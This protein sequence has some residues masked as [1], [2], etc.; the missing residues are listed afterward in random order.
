MGG[1]KMSD[2]FRLWEF[3]IKYC[4][5]IDQGVG[6]QHLAWLLEHERKHREMKASNLATDF[7][8]NLEINKEKNNERR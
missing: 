6:K 3:F 8:I 1:V 4:V 5:R 7:V 2:D